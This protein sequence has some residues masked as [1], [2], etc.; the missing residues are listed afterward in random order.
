MAGIAAQNDCLWRTPGSL[1]LYPISRM[2]L[3]QQTLKC[4]VVGRSGN[5]ICLESV[6][7]RACLLKV[8]QGRVLVTIMRSGANEGEESSSQTR[9][10]AS[11]E[12]DWL[13]QNLLHHLSRPQLSLSKVR[14]KQTHRHTHTHLPATFMENYVLMDAAK[15]CPR[16]LASLSQRPPPSTCDEPFQHCAQSRDQQ[17]IRRTGPARTRRGPIIPGMLFPNVYYCQPCCNTLHIGLQRWFT[18]KVAVG[19]WR[20][21]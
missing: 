1:L 7:Y 15:G 14:H 11:A 17:R 10:A 19:K 21:L 5:V 9:L 3:V 12:Y 8:N 2:L 13:Q 16:T 6:A 18:V 20:V 4:G